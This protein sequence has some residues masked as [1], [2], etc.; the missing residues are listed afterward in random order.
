M[1]A[2]IAMNTHATWCVIGLADQQD[3]TAVK[4][5]VN[6]LYIGRASA[7]AVDVSMPRLECVKTKLSD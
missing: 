4:S 5:R 2:R 3:C 1:H 6:L 7:H